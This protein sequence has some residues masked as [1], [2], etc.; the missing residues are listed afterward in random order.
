MMPCYALEN[1][2]PWEVTTMVG[3]KDTLKSTHKGNLI[4]NN[5]VFT[6]VLFVTGL[7][8]T[9]ISKLQVQLEKQGCK[10]VS[11]NGY[12][13]SQRIVTICSMLS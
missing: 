13:T 1:A 7:L 4:F 11:K 2:E 5:L 9:L 6:D 8:Q 10:I 3:N 12:E